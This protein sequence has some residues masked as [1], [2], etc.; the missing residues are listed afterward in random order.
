MQQTKQV[1]VTVLTGF[2]G[3]GE[4]LLV[5]ASIKDGPDL[6]FT[7]FRNMVPSLKCCLL[8]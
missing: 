4:L 3:A 2:L 1:P 6:Y 7:L 5:D 8:K